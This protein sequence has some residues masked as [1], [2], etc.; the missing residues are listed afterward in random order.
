[1]AT[2]VIDDF[3][4]TGRNRATI[5]V[6]SVAEVLV[7]PMAAGPAVVGTVDAFLLHF[8]NLTVAGLDYA[9]AREAAR[10]RAATSLKTPDALILA[11]AQ[12]SGIEHVVANDAS[13]AKAIGKVALSVTLCH[14]DVHAPI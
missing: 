13:W 10:L 7:R 12:M 4:R 11:T 5:S 8:P 3:I 1:M 2:V 14:L 6:V 9:I